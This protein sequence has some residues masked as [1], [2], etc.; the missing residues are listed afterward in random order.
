VG[1]TAVVE[2]LAL[3]IANGEAPASLEGVRI[4]SL[5]VGSLV[6]GTRN[7][8]DFEERLTSLVSELSSRPDLVLFVDEIHMLAGASSGAADAANL[9]KPALQSERIRC[10]GATTHGEYAK[11][12]D[13]DPAMARRFQPVVVPE[14]GRSE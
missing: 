7:R 4:L 3:R 1:K 13:A 12:F 2:G 9:L 11:Y 6:G 8:G 5:D 14:P 10:I